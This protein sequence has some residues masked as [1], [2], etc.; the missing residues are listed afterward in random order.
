MRIPNALRPLLPWI[1]LAAVLLLATFGV[2]LIAGTMGVETPLDELAYRGCY[3]DPAALA[4]PPG[5]DGQ[6]VNYLHTCGDR[7]YESQGRRVQFTGL[8]WF[9]METGTYAPHGLW[10]RNWQSLLDQVV[11]LGYN[12]IRLP[13]SN[14]TLH[15]QTP[16][17][18]I[19][20]DLNPDLRGLN[21]L[22]MLDKIIE[23]ARAR[24][25]R[26]V[27]DRHRPTT[28][29]QSELWYT[30][31][32]GEEQWLA[33]WRLLAERYRGNDTVVAFDLHNEPRGPATWGS[34]D[35][36]T[37]WRL[38]AERAGNEILAINPH[39]LIF[40]E[41]VERV[42][43]N[44]YWWGGNL[45][46]VREHPVR[47]AVP[48]RVVYSPHEYGPAVYRQAWFDDPDYP[49]NLP[50]LWDKQWGYIA[51][52]RL[53]PVVV[54][55][56]GAVS[57]GGDK[58][59]VW[60]RTLVD[61]MRRNRIGYMAWSLNPNSQFTG[62][63]L[64]EDWF[65]V[66]E[67][68]HELYRSYLAPPMVDGAGLAGV[69]MDDSIRARVQ[70]QARESDEAANNVSFALRVQNDGGKAIALSKVELRYWF[71]ADDPYD[72]APVVEVD[73]AAVGTEKVRGEAV[74]A[75]RGGQDHYIRITFGAEAGSI[76]P[77]ATSGDILVR[78][79]N[80]DWTVYEQGNDFSFAADGGMRDAPRIAL[81]YDGER[82]WGEEP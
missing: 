5:P 42:G 15:A 52:E 71:T 69:R 36:A 3:A 29:A 20:Y 17:Q 51:K 56:F 11:E 32:V 27:L 26:V 49:R 72:A 53:A 14:E 6:A 74:E 46:A 25:L 10:T 34:G 40:V 37:D 50:G 70:Y 63:I 28:E 61:Y 12:S 7:L 57:T 80:T 78:L 24:G 35:P 16:S 66:S 30:E 81:Y 21:G 73:W 8:N 64:D 44:W 22:Q 82:I 60:Q 9:G 77:Y 75:Y 41:G 79:H 4:P 58:E 33:D 48:N 67:N 43:D 2:F 65:S 1:G 13:V 19:N 62:G 68:R 47:L 23:G 18:A 59:G 55:E 45:I 76:Q 31:E 54:G 38:A 39:L